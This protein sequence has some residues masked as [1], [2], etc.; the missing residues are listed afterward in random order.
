MSLLKTRL[1]AE[2]SAF[3]LVDWIAHAPEFAATTVQVAFVGPD[4]KLVS[5]S[6]ERKPKPVD[7]SDREHVRVHLNGAA[8]LFIGK[9]VTGRISGQTTIQISDRVESADGRL[10]GV[11]VF[12]L[13]PEFLTTLHRSVQLGKDR[14]DDFG[15]NGR[16]DPRVLRWLSEIR[17]RIYRQILIESE[18]D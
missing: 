3:D 7:L 2:G 15:R 16:R 8:G 14:I 1:A 10:A 11:L 13:S 9:P 5:T 18:G 17:R 4:G 12:S 6:L